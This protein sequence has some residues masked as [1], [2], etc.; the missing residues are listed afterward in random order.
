MKKQIID[1]LHYKHQLVVKTDRSHQWMIFD[2]LMTKAHEKK[3]LKILLVANDMDIPELF[4][5]MSDIA[6][7]HDC[8]V[9]QFFKEVVTP[10]GTI[11]RFTKP[12]DLFLVGNNKDYVVLFTDVEK[13]VRKHFNEYTKYKLIYAYE[14]QQNSIIF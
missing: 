11:L 12:E 1:Q 7:E 3:G 8:N 10:N 6:E 4:E 2:Y 9:S 5:H 14:H 13:A